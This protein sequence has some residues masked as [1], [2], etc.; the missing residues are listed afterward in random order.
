MDEHCEVRAATVARTDNDR[1]LSAADRSGAAGRY[2]L[3][4]R[5]CLAPSLAFRGQECRHTSDL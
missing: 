5:I 4:P 2:C 1:R 3:P